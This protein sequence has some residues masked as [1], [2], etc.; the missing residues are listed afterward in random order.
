MG[1]VA[2]AGRV[3]VRKSATG[4]HG[5]P[6]AGLLGPLMATVVLPYRGRAAAA[7]AAAA[8]ELQISQADSRLRPA[9]RSRVSGPAGRKSGVGQFRPTLRTFTVLSTIAE[10]P[11]LNNREVSERAEVSDQGQISR[12]LWRLED[13][14]LLRNTGCWEQDTPKAWSLTPLGE[15]ALCASRPHVAR[16]V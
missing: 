9:D 12:L 6:L 13:Q 8:V 15:Q 14:G 1:A 5:G 16:G 11:G 4:P 7:A 10:R 2:D 3:R